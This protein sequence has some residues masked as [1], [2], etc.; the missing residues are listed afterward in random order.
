MSSCC[1]IPLYCQFTCIHLERKQLNLL[2]CLSLCLYLMYNNIINENCIYFSYLRTIRWGVRYHLLA[3]KPYILEI[4]NNI[5]NSERVTFLGIKV[6]DL[7]SRLHLKFYN[8]CSIKGSDSI[9]GM[10]VHNTAR[11]VSTSFE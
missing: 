9:S 4:L 1:T 11:T 8:I 6:D 5:V 10:L 2:S 3:V 7:C